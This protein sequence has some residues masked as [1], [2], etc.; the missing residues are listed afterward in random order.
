MNERLTVF[1]SGNWGL[2]LADQAAR[3]HTP[4]MVYVRRP[5]LKDFLEEHRSH[6][7]FLRHLKFPVQV[8]FSSD[9]EEAALYAPNWVIAVP[10]QHMREV[11]QKLQP[12]VGRARYA[13][14]AAKGLEVGTDRRMSEVLRECWPEVPTEVGVLSGPNLAGEI[15]MGQPAASVL[16][17]SPELFRTVANILGQGNLRL[18]GH[19]DVPGVELGGA[20][21]NILAIAVG[22]AAQS[23][24]G[25]NA[26]AAIMTR[27]LHEMGRLAVKMGA[28]WETLAGLSGLGDVVAT[29]SSPQ[30]RNRW[31]G[32]ELAKGRSVADILAS[33][34]MVVEG[35][36]TAYA[37]KDL[38][39]KFGLPL[40]ITAEVVEIFNG[41]SVKLA[42]EALMSRERVQESDR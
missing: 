31:M 17:G 9:L 33:T 39:D 15:S 18:Y 23:G 24:L 35:V 4:V 36:P 19:R 5:D 22:I 32:Q 41:K 1:G 11:G 13:I 42:V 7:Q 10:S 12:W 21:K 38:G 3:S 8:S 20:F 2:V 34:P 28:Q 37:A 27:G 40:P 6:P 30:S 26:Q 25:D 16:A 29:S 14:S